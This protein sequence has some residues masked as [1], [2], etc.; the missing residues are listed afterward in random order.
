MFGW[1]SDELSFGSRN[2][3]TQH[4]HCT[5]GGSTN[6]PVWMVIGQS[7]LHIALSLHASKL[8]LHDVLRVSR[9]DVLQGMNEHCQLRQWPV[10]TVPMS[11][12]E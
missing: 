10:T 12:N 2:D 9:S 3:A 11:N 6:D 4:G 1:E 5:A 7:V 8:T